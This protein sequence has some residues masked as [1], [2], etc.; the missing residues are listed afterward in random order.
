LKGVT[1]ALDRERF[2]ERQANRT[3]VPD[4]DVGLARH[5]IGGEL[6]TWDVTLTVPVPLFFWQAKKGAIAEARA[7]TSA[8]VHEAE[9]LRQWVLNEV[10]QAYRNA[11]AAHEQIRHLETEV[12]A[13][14]R[15]TYEMFAFAYKEGE[16]EGLELIAARRTLL[17]ARQSHAEALFTSSV[18]VAA[19]QRAVG[20]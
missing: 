8:A 6:S 3:N 2:L 15:E 12:L 17:E 1:A 5:R 13:K 4:L 14:A 11:V 9:R 16:I 18:A 19:L 10:E 20:Q 7:N